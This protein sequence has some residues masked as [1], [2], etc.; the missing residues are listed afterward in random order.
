[1]ASFDETIDK[2]VE[3][4]AIPGVVL[5]AKDK[6]GSQHYHH[7]VFSFLRILTN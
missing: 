3:D 2:L 7:F 6:A 4:R 5:L 1:M